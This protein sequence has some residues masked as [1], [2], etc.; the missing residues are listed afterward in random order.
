MQLFCNWRQYQ[1]PFEIAKYSG[2]QL[3]WHKWEKLQSSELRITNDKIGNG[4][5][6]DVVLAFN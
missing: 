2:L 4:V 6:H 1:L 3:N 5:L